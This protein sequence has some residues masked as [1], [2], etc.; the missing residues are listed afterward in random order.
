MSFSRRQ[1][2]MPVKVVLALVGLIF[3]WFSS[4]GRKGS[5]VPPENFAPSAVRFLSAQSEDN[6]IMLSWE[7]PLTQA[8]GVPL[9]DLAGFNVRRNKLIE[10]EQPHFLFLE[11]VKVGLPSDVARDEEKNKVS[12]TQPKIP[13]GSKY[14]FRD[15]DVKA[16][17]VYEY[18]VIPYNEAGIEG[19][20]TNGVRV[21]FS[22]AKGSTVESF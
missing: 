12:P 3:F 7:V 18:M 21:K 4:C 2:G 22:G 11:D 17:E 13:E 9:Q 14:S 1:T 6:F 19:V 15:Q 8:N 5:P 10:N 16:G 20:V